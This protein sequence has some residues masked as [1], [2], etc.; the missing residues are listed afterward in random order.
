M[1]VNIYD[2]TNLIPIAGKTVPAPTPD[3]VDA[4]Y[5]SSTTYSKGMTCISGNVRYR[6]INSTASSGH[7]PPNATYW[8]VL[9]VASQLK[10][11]YYSTSEIDTGDIW[12]DGSKIYKKTYV[13]T[14]NNMIASDAQNYPDYDYYIR[15]IS[16]DFDRRNITKVEGLTRYKTSTQADST[17]PI[18]YTTAVNE[19]EVLPFIYS[20]QITIIAKAPNTSSFIDSSTYYYLT[21][22]YTK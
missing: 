12:I 13:W 21:I 17:F 20:N 8:E 2:G 15:L 5:S 19:T 4:Q 1:S 14:G 9:S 7:Q 6:Y 22:Y 3:Y 16:S 10:G 18:P 11:G